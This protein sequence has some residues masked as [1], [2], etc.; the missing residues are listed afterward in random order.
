MWRLPLEDSIVT[1]QTF[2][3]GLVLV[4]LPIVCGVIYQAGRLSQ[5]VDYL[6]RDVD[7]IPAAMKEG[8]A[9]IIR[10]IRDGSE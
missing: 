4:L 8:F 7:A 5:R 10:L 9:Q 6:Q 3:R 2:L 1:D